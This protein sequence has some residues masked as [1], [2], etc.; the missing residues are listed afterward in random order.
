MFDPSGR[1]TKEYF[2]GANLPKIFRQHID[3]LPR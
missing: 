2:I 1:L 3:V